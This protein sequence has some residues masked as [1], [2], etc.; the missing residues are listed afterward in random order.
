[1]NLLFKKNYLVLDMI[2][3]LCA[4]QS[5]P[6]IKEISLTEIALDTLAGIYVVPSNPNVVSLFLVDSNLKSRLF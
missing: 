4:A 5:F 3:N 2:W 6:K 1:M